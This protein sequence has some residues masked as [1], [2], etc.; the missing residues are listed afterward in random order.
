MVDVIYVGNGG[1]ISC[2][3]VM[4]TT[5]YLDGTWMVYQYWD[6]GFWMVS[7]WFLEAGAALACSSGAVRYPA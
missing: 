1:H 2:Y 4:V 5:E 6:L 7:G 3:L